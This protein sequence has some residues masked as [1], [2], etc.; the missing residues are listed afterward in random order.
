MAK[1]RRE[2]PSR[3]FRELNLLHPDLAA[4]IG[5]YRMRLAA[6]HAGYPVL[7][8][9][10]P[11]VPDGWGIFPQVPFR[12]NVIYRGSAAA[13][14]YSHHQALTKFGDKYVA[15]WSNGFLHEDYVGQEVHY[16]WSADG[17]KWS[18]PAVLVHTPAESNLVQT[19]SGLFAGNGKV[20]IYVGVA[21]DFGRDKAP[22]G[23]YSL[24][25]QRIRLDVYVTSD[26]KTWTRHE[27][28][29]DNIY[30]VEGPRPTREGKLLCCGFDL[31]DMHAIVLIW[32]DPNHP[33][34]PPRRVHIPPSPEG[35][36]PEEGT[37]YQT[38]DGRIWM[39]QRD[40]KCSC[41]L[42]LTF[43]DD[44]GE[45]W[46]DLVRTDFP[47]TTSRAF[48]GRLNDGRYYLVGNNYDV[49]LDRRRLLLALSDDGY[50]FNRQYTLIEG[51]TT[52]R[53]N[54]RHKEDG[55][56]YPNCFADG[57]KLFVIYSVNKEDIEVG[58]VDTS[59]ID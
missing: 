38:D 33:E 9:W 48:A 36:H 21:H 40:N 1:S 12:R 35:I 56:H 18:D 49:L 23:M 19:N 14:A 43:S 41:R 30:L 50:V 57:D 37:W 15:S 32:D 59:K 26:L 28:I 31:T 52:R 27:N 34:H 46:S 54:G 55:Y 29:C 8:D 13:W 44:G 47:N 20:Y 39:Y 25:P 42:G 11:V 58:M 17:E 51:P 16:A 3:T 53:I 10:H 22:P 5:R 45:S 24:T 4:R 2:I 6:G 7:T